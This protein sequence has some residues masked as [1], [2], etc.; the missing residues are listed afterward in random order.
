MRIR[1]S[2]LSAAYCLPFSVAKV[3]EVIRFVE[4][5]SFSFS[6]KD[7]LKKLIPPREPPTT[8]VL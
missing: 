6:L 2:M 5:F 1:E 4:T 3:I 8:Y 7:L